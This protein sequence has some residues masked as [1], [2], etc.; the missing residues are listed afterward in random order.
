M[1]GRKAGTDGKKSGREQ[2][3]TNK[4]AAAPTDEASG[5]TSVLT[6]CLGYA[7]PVIP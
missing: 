1:P 5:F 6:R 7:F 2:R 4:K 3:G